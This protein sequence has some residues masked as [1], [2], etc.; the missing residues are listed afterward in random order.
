MRYIRNFCIIAHV[1][2]GK[3]TL[4]DRLLELT[5]TVDIKDKNMQLLDN[6]DLEKERGITIKSHAVQMNY[7]YKNHIYTLNLIDTPGHIDFS[8]EVK[9]SIS[10]CEGAL[11]VVDCIKGIQAQTVSNLSLALK[12]NLVIIPVLNKIDLIDNNNYGNIIDDIINLLKCSKKDIIPASAKI[13]LGIRK[14]LENIIIKIPFPKGNSNNPLQAF[15]FDSIYN[16]FTGIEFFFRVKNGCIKKGQKLK[17]L[18]TNKIF[19]AND[20]GCLKLK[21]ISKDKIEA[22]DV[23]YL[24]SGIKNNFEVKVGDTITDFYRSAKNP[25]KK[26]EDI[27]HMVFASIYPIKYN[28]YEDL[29][30]AMEKLQLNDASIYFKPESSSAL[31]Y[32]F[33][34]G[35]LGMLHLEIIKDRIE[36]EYGISVIVTIPNVSYKIYTKNKSF[37]VNVPS[38]FPEYGTFKKVEE[39]Y[40]LVSIITQ[41]NDIG[42]IISLCMKKRGI[43]MDQNY[44]SSGKV[45][46]SFEMPLSEIIIDFYDKLKT[47]TKGYASFDYQFIEYRESD[48][49]KIIVLINRE[50]IESLSMLSHKSKSEILAKKICKKLSALIPKHQFSIPIQAS[51]SGKIIARETIKSLR[52]DV[53]GKCYGGDITRK[54]KLLNKQKKGKKKMRELGKVNIPSSAFMTFLKIKD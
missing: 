47:I 24:I 28:E 10:S 23:G 42:D 17:F 25:V 11:L 31:G 50:K 38:N 3:S 29:R 5:N 1:D 34:C 39:P 41:N 12:N 37:F 4:A 20:I 36:R 53:I 8:Y 40:V 48:L 15:V 51:I 7:K 19:Y 21:K 32:G 30:T 9:R 44:L 45:Q 43:I 13:G 33:H 54:K 2:H 49:R 22:G 46:I 26:F 18:S 27:K 52:K 6:M 14:I 16:P 35:F